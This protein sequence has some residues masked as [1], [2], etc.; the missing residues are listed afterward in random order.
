MPAPTTGNYQNGQILSNSYDGNTQFYGEMAKVGRPKQITDYTG[1]TYTNS[2]NSVAQ[3]SVITMGTVVAPGTYG[4]RTKIGI[5]GTQIDTNI[6][7]IAGDTIA[8]AQARLLAALKADQRL[9][10][11][12]FA[13]VAATITAT[14]KRAGTI[15]GFDLTTAN[16]GVGYSAVDTVLP[17][18]PISLKVGRLVV[19]TPADQLAFEVTAPNSNLHTA[20]ARYPTVAA[21]LDFLVGIVIESEAQGQDIFGSPFAESEI[22]PYKAFSV[23]ERGEF[24]FNPVNDVNGSSVLHCYLSGA[25]IGRIRAGADGILTAPL[26][27]APTARR[28]TLQNAIKANQTAYLSIR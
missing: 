27:A 9:T 28:I 4:V 15:F 14:Q 17:R 21:D 6:T 25:N 19:C 1:K 18:D 16:G 20:P 2:A 13:S 22:I 8:I 26:S 10:S 7:T 23:G 3:V 11:I 5:N 12:A 24:G